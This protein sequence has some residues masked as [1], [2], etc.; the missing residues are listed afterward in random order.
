MRSKVA[1]V[2]T[3]VLF[4]LRRRLHVFSFVIAT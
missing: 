2:I 3:S 1:N 4:P